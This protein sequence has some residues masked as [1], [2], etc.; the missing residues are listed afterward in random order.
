MLVGYRI[1]CTYEPVDTHW[2]I[3]AVYKDTLDEALVAFLDF[4]Q[5]HWD[6]LSLQP[7]FAAPSRAKP[8]HA[9]TRQL[10]LW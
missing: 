1:C 8:L 7:M 4:Q 10:S 9:V 5:Q 2:Q 3:Y 6:R